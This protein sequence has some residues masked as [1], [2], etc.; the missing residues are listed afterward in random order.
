MSIVMRPSGSHLMMRPSFVQ[1][2]RDRHCHEHVYDR[3]SI[4]V[5]FSFFHR[6]FF[7]VEKSPMSQGTNPSHTVG[8][9]K[10]SKAASSSGPA[11]EIHDFLARVHHRT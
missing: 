3:L 2:H 11:A 6:S 1:A 8:N 5:V 7:S 10:A 4:Y 9:L